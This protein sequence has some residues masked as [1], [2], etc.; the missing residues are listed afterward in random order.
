MDNRTRRK[1]SEAMKGK[2]KGKI[3]WMKGR[4]PWNKGVSR[5]D[6]VKRKISKANKGENH[7]M[8]GKY[9]S[10]ETKQKMRLTRLRNMEA[11]H[12]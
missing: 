8:F 7:P 1:I 11:E 12:G 4:I 2:N 5:S 6:E 3:S 10:E 9:H